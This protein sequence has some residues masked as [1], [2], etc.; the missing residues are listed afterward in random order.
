MNLIPFFDA[1]CD[2]LSRLYREGGTLRANDGQYD[3]DRAGRFAP[4]AQF[5]AVWDCPFDTLYPFFQESLRANADRMM[6]CRTAADARAAGE[7]GQLAAFLS[8]EGGETADCSPDR[9]ERAYD[10]GAR[11]VSLTWNHDNALGGGIGGDGRGLSEAGRSFVRRAKDLSM[12]VDVSH[13]SER[14]FWDLAG[15]MAGAPFIASHSNVKAVCAHRRNL[16]DEQLGIIV[17]SN[18]FTGIN[19]Y[20]DFLSDSG[21]AT[22]ED[23]FTHIEHFLSLG[24]TGH[25]GLGCDLDGCDVL[26]GGIRGVQDLGELYNYLLRKNYG[27]SLVRE[28]FYENLLEVVERV[29]GM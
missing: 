13:L 17:K 29:C 24:G 5:F 12:L 28:I 3:L 4:A 1:H 25:I 26:P 23:V 14:S 6:F 21:T 20:A 15:E 10:L 11:M 8:L 22:L 18:G 27:E 16:T 2:T 19:L 9:L 7:R